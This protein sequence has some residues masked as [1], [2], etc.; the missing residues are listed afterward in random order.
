MHAGVKA[1]FLFA[2]FELL[3]IEVFSRSLRRQNVLTAWMDINL[4][5][6]YF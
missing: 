4:R 2:L 3:T 6:E 1:K 5:E